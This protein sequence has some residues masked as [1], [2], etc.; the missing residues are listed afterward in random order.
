[1]KT[2]LKVY[3]AY[4]SF[5]LAVSWLFTQIFYHQARLIRYPVYIRG[6]RHI[7]WGKGFT[8][9][10]GLRM[11]A[12]VENGIAIDIGHGVQLNDYVHIAAIE[13]VTIGNDVLIASKVFITDHNHGSY[14]KDAPHSSPATPP[15]SRPLIS[16][17]VV[18]GDRVWL[19]ENVS[20]LAG[21]TIGEGVVVAANSVVTHD[22]PPNTIAAGAP[23]RIIK[24][25]DNDSASWISI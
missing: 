15:A 6:K 2:I 17:P 1:M 10:V 19:G 13:S 5:R 22:L 18:I 21:V 16:A 3:G 12:F 23:A 9:G 24:H 20:V 7:Q 25:Y 8:T 4:G 11:D 14:G